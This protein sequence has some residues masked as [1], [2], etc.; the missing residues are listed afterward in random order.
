MN[1]ASSSVIHI[2][3]LIRNAWHVST[4]QCLI[5]MFNYTHIRHLQ[6]HRDHLSQ[7]AHHGP[8]C[9][10][11]FQKLP[12][13]AKDLVFSK[14]METKYLLHALQGTTIYICVNRKK[15][16]TL[17]F[18][19]S[20]PSINPFPLTSPKTSYSSRSFCRPRTSTSPTLPQFSCKFSS[21]I[22]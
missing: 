18:T 16:I 3:G 6:F 11:K 12:L 17:S 10:P 2:G 7:R 21:S 22:T 14:K 15:T 20:I 5:F 1:C 8:L 4:K 9:C 13:K 19:S